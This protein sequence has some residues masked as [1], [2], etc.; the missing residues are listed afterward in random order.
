MLKTTRGYYELL[1][2]QNVKERFTIV[3]KQIYCI[4]NNRHKIKTQEHRTQCYRGR[5]V[6]VMFNALSSAQEASNRLG[7]AMAKAVGDNHLATVGLNDNIG[8]KQML[9]N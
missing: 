4:I 5:C 1:G 6:P 2:G 8:K 9:V 7:I 3:A